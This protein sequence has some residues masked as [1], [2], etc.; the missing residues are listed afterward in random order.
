MKKTYI[1]IF[2]LLLVTLLTSCD[3]GAS[4]EAL[5]EAANEKL[6]FAV[7]A[8]M[9]N[10]DVRESVHSAMDASP[11]HEHKLVFGEFLNQPEGAALK[12]AI[13]QKLGGE[14]VLNGLLDELPS[15]DFYLPYETHRETWEHAKDNLFVTCV[16]TPNAEVATSYHPNGS[17]ETFTS[18]EAIEEAKIAAMFSLHPE[19]PKVHRNSS[20]SREM[21]YS[22]LGSAN[23]GITQDNEATYV[24]KIVNYTADG[25]FGGNCEFYFMARR[26]DESHA[27]ES[28]QVSVESAL[29]AKI[30][31]SDSAPTKK[32]DLFIYNG[33]V[34]GANKLKVRVKEADGGGTG[35]DDDYGFFIADGPD[36]YD[37]S[38]NQGRSFPKATITVDNQ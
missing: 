2:G 26:L 8:A 25:V 32:T 18:R 10:P 15:M 31:N 14:D 20:N 17:T 24:T 38:K 35:G 28:S 34:S 33:P 5:P 36:D 30:K 21:G 4:P 9:G 19:E 6:A 3:Q 27:T 23:S 13:A 7:A 11:Y 12:K 22:V 29:I 37:T 16:L 1:L